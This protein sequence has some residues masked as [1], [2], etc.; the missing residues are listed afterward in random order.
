MLWFKS[1][2]DKIVD[3][4]GLGNGIEITK[5]GITELTM[6][7]DAITGYLVINAE[8]IDEAIKIAQNCPIITSTKVYEVMSRE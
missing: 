5:N 7:K 1:I 3:Q 8:N 6:D 2:E 4:V